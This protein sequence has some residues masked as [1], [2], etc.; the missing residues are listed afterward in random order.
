MIARIRV[1]S[2]AGDFPISINPFPAIATSRWPLGACDHFGVTRPDT[3]SPNFNSWHCL[4]TLWR[5]PSP[6]RR[7]NSEGISSR[8]RRRENALKSGL[9]P[10][11]VRVRVYL[12]LSIWN[13]YFSF[14]WQPQIRRRWL[15]HRC[16]NRCPWTSRADPHRTSSRP[17]WPSPPELPPR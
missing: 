10:E 3:W 6:D 4:P 16:P 5:C 9:F 17:D 11:G 12:V 1:A 8:A 7:R 14:A 13:S 15:A 2:V